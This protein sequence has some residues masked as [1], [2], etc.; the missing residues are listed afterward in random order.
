LVYHT[1]LFFGHCYHRQINKCLG[2]SVGQF[3]MSSSA[4][5][6]RVGKWLDQTSVRD[7]DHRSRGVGGVTPLPVL[8]Y[9]VGRLR[10][11]GQNATRPKARKVFWSFSYSSAHCNTKQLAH[12]QVL[13]HRGHGVKP[14]LGVIGEGPLQVVLL[15]FL[16]QQ[17]IWLHAMQGTHL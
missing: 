1:I 6:T 8:V 4:H 17:A 12:G 15:P 5:C 9:S 7:L 16:P 13:G 11:S 10:V 2:Q 3:T 14:P